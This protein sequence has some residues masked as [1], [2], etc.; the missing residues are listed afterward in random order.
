MKRIVTET[1]WVGFMAL[2]ALV[3]ITAWQTVSDAKP[4]PV[5]YI[6][7]VKTALK[8]PVPIEP[9][10]FFRAPKITLTERQFDCLA[11]NIYYEAG[12]E[13]YYGKIAVAQVTWNRVRHGRWGDTVCRV[14]YAKKQFSWTH[15]NKPAPRGPL[16]EQS[17][18]AARDFLNGTRLHAVKGSK[19]YHAVYIDAPKW[20]EPMRELATIGQHKF[21]RFHK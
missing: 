12:V 7:P 9:A 11:R 18:K 17:K 13:D 15:Q 19:Y 1:L 20:T 21:Y 5:D 10:E 14:V 4:H 2:L 6:Q 16:W 8:E 3:M